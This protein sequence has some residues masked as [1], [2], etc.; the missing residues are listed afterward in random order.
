MATLMLPYSIHRTLCTFSVT[1]DKGS[2]ASVHV[3]ANFPAA[4][5]DQRSGHQLGRR[6]RFRRLSGRRR[7]S[8]GCLTKITVRAGNKRKSRRTG[9]EPRGPVSLRVADLDNNGGLDLLLLATTPVGSTVWL[10][11]EQGQFH[12]HRDIQFGD[13]LLDVADVNSDGRLDVLGF[14]TEGQAIQSINSSS[15]NYHWQ[16]VRPRASNAVG[17]QR[18]NPFGVGGEMEIRSGLLVQKAGDHWSTDSLWSGRADELRRHQDRMAQRHC[19]RR[20]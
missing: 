7:Q 13:S 1:N 10:S 5:R 6:L 2:S 18:I 4:R 3:P 11:D 19:P 17:D 8:R 16:L 20:V 15:K 14:T 12:L 9:E